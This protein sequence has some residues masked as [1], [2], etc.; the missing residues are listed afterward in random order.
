[1]TCSEQFKNLTH[2]RQ[3]ETLKSIAMLLCLASR[4]KSNGD[5]KEKCQICDCGPQRQRPVHGI[6]SRT[7]HGF[8]DEELLTFLSQLLDD[9]HFRRSK[10]LRVLAAT[11]IRRLSN[12]VDHRE[13]SMLSWKAV[14]T[15]LMRSLQSSV[16]ELRIACAEAL[17]SYLREDLSENVRVRNRLDALDFL[18]CLTEKNNLTDQ[19]T[20]VFTWGLI[21]KTCGDAE[22]NLALIQLIDY[23]GHHHSLVSGAAYQEILDLASSRSCTPL[24]MLKPFW[25]SL[26]TH[27]VKDTISCPQKVQQLSDLLGMGVN[28]L[29]LLTQTDTIPYLILTR[30]RDVL[31]R[32]A[33]A[34]GPTMTVQ[35]LW[36][37]PSKNLAVVLA[38][39]LVQPSED[40]EH[41]AIALLRDAAPSFA[42][43]DLAALVKVDPILISCEILK[44]AADCPDSKKPQVSRLLH[45]S[46]L[47]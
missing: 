7:H 3:V 4:V 29:L 15:W 38:F 20:L 41:E 24:E 5:S 11:A 6:W 23:L 8:E 18:K 46:K 27:V 9:S 28:D 31:Q 30:K 10:H 39:L 2:E 33:Q 32:I 43:T 1:M 36:L 44:H 45:L 37:Q 14:G 34:R 47:H 22:L 21:G 19:D 13:A 40:A 16:R 25:S 26:A 42:E 17:V 12:H 35:D